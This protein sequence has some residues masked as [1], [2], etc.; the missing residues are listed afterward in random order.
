[1]GYADVGEG[2]QGNTSSSNN[3]VRR[4]EDGRRN[5]GDGGEEGDVDV[6]PEYGIRNGGPRPQSYFD[7]NPTGP[8][9]SSDGRKSTTAGLG[10]Y[11][12]NIGF[13]DE[14]NSPRGMVTRPA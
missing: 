4:T 14:D 8:G 10:S 12:D 7:S 2:N 3:N 9:D 5:F 6:V 1:L 13:S 11:R